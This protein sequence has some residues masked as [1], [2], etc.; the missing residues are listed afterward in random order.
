MKKLSLALMLMG[1]S[2]T[3]AYAGG[4]DY[5]EPEESG[6]FMIG[7]ELLYAN[8]CDSDFL[9]AE[10]E[11][12]TDGNTVF[13]NFGLDFDYDW[14]YHID[15]AYA[16]PGDGPD[17]YLGFTSICTD[18][19]KTRSQINGTNLNGING[20]NF[21]VNGVPSGVAEGKTE[22]DYKDV[23]LL[24]GK[25]F[26]LQNRYHFHPFAGV[27]Y[28]SIDSSD[29]A[30]FYLNS[31]LAATG[32][33][34]NCFSGVGPRAGI[35]GAMEIANGF[36]LVAR[37]AGSILIGSNDWKYYTTN[38]GLLTANIPS[39]FL[40]KSDDCTVCVPETDYRLGVN[41]TYEFSPDSAFG[42]ELGWTAVHYF[43]VMDKSNAQILDVSGKASDWGFQGP[44]LRLQA[45]IA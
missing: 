39:T 8:V 37:A 12:T 44:Y 32:K 25:E 1:L 33:I 23:D 38:T 29:K 41:Y 45:N 22:Y 3:A 20:L 5:Q 6:V 10:R 18:D 35:D 42:V 7:V 4:I 28:A 34:D 11:E 19:S 26:V 24:L 15:V 14:A 2:S 21:V 13:Q 36:S 27:R 40:A 43:D 31:Q 30:S 17:I 9:F 16:M